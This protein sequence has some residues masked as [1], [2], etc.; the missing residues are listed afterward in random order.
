MKKKVFKTELVKRGFEPVLTLFSKPKKKQLAI[1]LV[2]VLL[3]S[4]FYFFKNQLIV[5]TVNGKPIWRLTL[6]NE[7]EKQAGQG[8]LDSLITRTLI[9]Q[10]AQ[11]QKVV[12]SEDEV[13]S[14]V[15]RIEEEIRQQGQDL[16]SL[17]ALQGISRVDLQEQIKIQKMIEKILGVNIKVTDEEIADFLEEN[18]EFISEDL[19]LEE[20]R[21]DAREQLRKQ[22]INEEITNWIAS[23]KEEA[24]INYW[25]SF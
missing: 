12:V 23:L 3:V 17:L 22:K 7:L 25:R 19:S 1:F 16:D 9:L 4:L 13:N 10:E 2:F 24:T 11:K 5:A 8:V 6:V 15:G 18:K 20:A 14:E 21:E